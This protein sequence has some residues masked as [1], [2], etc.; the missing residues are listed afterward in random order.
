M[1]ND[2]N[3]EMAHESELD[4][5]SGRKRLAMGK[6]Y[7]SGDFGVE[8]LSGVQGHDTK[9]AILKDH[10]RGARPPVGHNQ[11]NPDHGEFK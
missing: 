7:P 6:P 11:A 5:F 2:V 8:P 10:E 3:H 4:G 9:D 1:A